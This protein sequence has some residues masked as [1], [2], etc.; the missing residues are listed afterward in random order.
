VYSLGYDIGSSFIKASI[1]DLE[2]GTSVAH[3]FQPETEMPISARRPGWA[4]QDPEVW[5]TALKNVT[6]ELISRHSLDTSRIKCVGIT[7][8][9]HGLVLVD[10]SFNVL[11]PAIIWCDSRAVEIGQQAFM[12]IGKKR[13]LESFLNSPGNFTASKLF[14]VKENEPEVFKRVF[15]FLLPGDYIAMK[16][17]GNL[18]TTVSGLTEG[19]FWNFK[20]NALASE[21]LDFYGIDQEL[22]P[23]VV[24]TFG[25]QGEITPEIA[26]ELTIPAG[27][28]I[29]YR[30]GDQP[31]NALSLN[32]LNPGEA[33]ANAGTSG[34][35]FGVSDRVRYDPKSRVNLFAHV[36]HSADQPRLGILLCING[37]GIL[38]SWLKKYMAAGVSYKDMDKSAAGIPAGSNELMIF[39][40]GNGAERMLENRNIG[41]RI[42]GLDFNRHADSHI[43]RAAQ[44]G[45]A[46]AFRYGMDIMKEM[47]VETKIIRAGMANMFLSP[48]FN[49]ILAGV[50]GSEIE[51]YD[52]D[53][54]QGAARGAA[55]GSGIFKSFSEAFAYLKLKKRIRPDSAHRGLYEDIY[56]RWKNHLD[57]FLIDLFA[58][59][60]K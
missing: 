42:L 29:C 5:W 17:T 8:Q 49:V 34:V 52:T 32:V 33:A 51:L 16:L 46:F 47:G 55:I 39:P 1:L 2:K 6:R 26:K 3:A 38:Y 14:W 12:A 22:I 53:G 40:F 23:A 56:E 54:A 43:F 37:V 30:A 41:C 7:Y 4:E 36:N 60:E 10:S 11:R 35:V 57:N 31:N 58:V 25:V 15:K 9:M 45:I 28:P 27:I 48:I 21:L 44:E 59:K 13:C 24:P 20:E 18:N 50:T 19:I